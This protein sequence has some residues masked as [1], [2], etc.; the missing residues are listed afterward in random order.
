MITTQFY[1]VAQSPIDFPGNDYIIGG[2]QD[3]GSYALINTVIEGTYL[4]GGDGAESVFD[5]VG[6]DFAITNYIYNDN[7]TRH[8][9]DASGNQENTDLILEMIYLFQIMK[10]FLL[11]LVHWIQIKMFIF[12]TQQVMMMQLVIALESLQVLKE[13]TGTPATFLIPNIAT[14]DADNYITTIEVSRHTTESSTVFVGLRSGEVKKITNANVILGYA[15]QPVI[16]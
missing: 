6:G 13:V 3:N 8:D 12:L 2:T 11:I 1:T 14:G 5:Q 4:Q 9:F 7:I 10:V 16:S 15:I